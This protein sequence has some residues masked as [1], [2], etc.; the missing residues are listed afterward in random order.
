MS[1]IAAVHF[2]VNTQAHD[3]R[4]PQLL[5]SLCWPPPRFC[6]TE[7]LRRLIFAATPDSRLSLSSPTATAISRGNSSAA[8]RRPSAGRDRRRPTDGN[9][10]GV[11]E[12]RLQN[13]A[14]SKRRSEC[15]RVSEVP[16]AKLS[17]L[18][19]NSRRHV[20][21]EIPGT[22]QSAALIPSRCGAGKVSRPSVGSWATSCRCY[23]R[24]PRK[25]CS[26]QGYRM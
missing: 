20:V 4:Q 1:F 17:G 3:T 10:H 15:C 8:E 11:R 14:R 9:C 23:L 12:G 25:A 5:A 6:G 18:Q 21:Q 2:A 7:A 19:G 22:E 24:I 13:Q 16:L 26:V